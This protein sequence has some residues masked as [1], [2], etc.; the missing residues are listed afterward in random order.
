MPKAR[1]MSKRF[2]VWRREWEDIVKVVIWKFQLYYGINVEPKSKVFP[3]FPVQLGYEVHNIKVSCTCIVDNNHLR[4]HPE[5]N[6][7]L[8]TGTTP[9]PALATPIA[10]RHSARI[11]V[12]PICSANYPRSA[13]HFTIYQLF[14]TFFWVMNSFGN[15]IKDINAPRIKYP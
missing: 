14:L 12:P 1:V 5:A 3:K 8:L 15:S 6:N 7:L 2:M 11:Q 9:N 13:S 4:L 10:R